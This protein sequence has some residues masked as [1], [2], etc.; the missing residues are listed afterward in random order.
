MQRVNAAPELQSALD[1]IVR[2]VREVMGTDV[3]TVYMA[4]HQAQ[5]LVFRATEGLNKD[6]IGRLSLSLIH[7]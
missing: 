6:G 7:I 2:N 3:C 1:I 5:A 4:D